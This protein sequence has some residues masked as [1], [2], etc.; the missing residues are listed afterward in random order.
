MKVRVGGELVRDQLGREETR[1]ADDLSTRDAEEEGD[2]IENVSEDQLERKVLDGKTLS[3]P[4]EQTHR[5]KGETL[6]TR[7][8]VY[9][10]SIS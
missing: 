6:M 7:N 10:P 5:E 8:K 1:D 2:R 9:E 3:N 4:G